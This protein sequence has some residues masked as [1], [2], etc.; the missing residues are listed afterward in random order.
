MAFNGGGTNVAGV[1]QIE[2]GILQIIE[3][4]EE[5]SATG[6]HSFD[7]IPLTNTKYK[8]KSISGRTSTGNY[9]ISTALSTIS[10]NDLTTSKYTTIQ[11]IT[12]LT[13]NSFSYN[14]EPFSLF[15]SDNNRL[16]ININTTTH[17]TTG[18]YKI[19]LLYNE[20]SI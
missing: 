6:D 4:V 1:Q 20:I 8:L 17:T 14:L 2:A 11:R 7:I 16:R 5:I 12:T 9:S 3:V 13:G 18:N 15:L 10:V 19:T